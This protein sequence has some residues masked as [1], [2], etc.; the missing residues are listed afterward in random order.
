MF[1]RMKTHLGSMNFHSIDEIMKNQQYLL[2]LLILSFGSLSVSRVHAQEA[3]FSHLTTD[4]G[5]SHN[6]VMAI[7]QDERGLLWFGTRNGVS[8]Y[9]GKEFKIFKQQKDNP[10]SILYNVISDLTGDGNGHVYIM[11]SRGISDYDIHKDTFTPIIQK[12]MRALFFD[13][14][15]YAASS[16]RIFRYENNLFVP[17]YQFPQKEVAI[18]KLYIHNDSVFIGTNQHGL[19]LL[20]PQKEL[21][22]LLPKG[23]IRDILRDSSGNYWITDKQGSGLYQI[24]GSQIT[25]FR[26]V[27]GDPAT[28]SSNIVH[29]CCE[30]KQGNIWVGTFEGLCKYDKKTKQFTRYAKHTTTK[31]L[32]HSSVWSLYC[33]KQ[34]TI[35]AG[36]YFG[37][38]NYINPEKQIYREYQASFQE[39]EGL[40]SPIVGRIIEDNKDNL[41]IC[42]EGG[43]VNKYNRLTR[44]FRWYT[45]SSSP[46]SLSHN[47]IR[48]IYYDSIQSTLWLGTHTG[49]LNKMDLKT[50]RITRYRH[51]EGNKESI[52]SNIIEGIISY[53]GKLLLATHGGI[54]VFNPQTEKCHL[55]LKDAKDLSETKS[56]MGLLFDHKGTLWVTNNNNGASA[57]NFKSKE[58]KTYLHNHAVEHSISSNS[59]NTIYEDSQ[60]RLW[61]CTNEQGLD[62]YRYE[63]DDFENLDVRKNG[64]SSNV[65]YNICELT[66]DRL[67]V[68]TDNGF[69]ILNVSEKRFENYGNLPLSSI[70]E[71]A[72]YK[73]RNGEVFIGGVTGMIAFY[74][75]DIHNTLRSY[76]IFPYR[77]IV[78]GEEITVGDKSGILT[79][80]FTSTP[81]ITLKADQN[82]FSIEYALTDYVPFNKDEIVYRLEGFSD[83]WTNTRGQ[84]TITYTNLSPGQYTLVIKAQSSIERQVPV[85]KLQIEILPP[86]YKTVWAYLIYIISAGAIAYYLVRAYNNH[87]K[88]RESLKFEKKHAED[89]EKLNQAKLRFFTNVSHEFRT[90]LTL[91]IG[92]MEMLLQLRSFTPMVYNKVLG[93]YKISL[94]LKE[95]ITELLDFR[96]QEQGYMSIKVKE[97]NMVDFVYEHYLLFQ[98]YAAQRKITF[99]FQ[100]TN[101]NIPVWYDAKQMQKVMNNLISNAFKHTGEGGE[102]SIS[103]RKRSQEVILEVADNGTGIPLKDIDKIF[104]RFYQIDGPGSLSNTGTGIGLALTKGIIELHHGT[105]EVFSEQGEGATFCVRLKSGNAHFTSEQISEAKEEVSILDTNVAG[106][107]FQ[108]SLLSE[109]QENDT[110]LKARGNKMLIVEDND[111]LRDMLINIFKEFYT[112]ITASNGA[113]GLEKA[114]S[115][116]P[117]IV[118]SDIIMPE[119]SGIELCQSIKKNPDICHIP[120]VLL[121]A[122][123]AIEH[124]IEGL[125]MG[126]DDYITKPFNIRILLSRCNN[127]V[128]NRIML[129]EK[130]SKQPQASANLLATNAMDKAFIDKVVK[131]I[132]THIGNE[133]FNVDMLATE[134]GIARTKLFTKLKAVTGQ[135]PADFIMTYRLKKAAIMLKNNFELNISEIADRLGFSSPAYFSKSFKEKYNVIPQVYR[136]GE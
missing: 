29:K 64:L 104:E 116:Q 86:V 11:T 87:I 117:D 105:I 49:G 22:H 75:K 80:D 108:E 62:L 119:M 55:L 100:K 107:E 31:S 74:E 111:S 13:K 20:T 127:L 136:K 57:Y 113:E 38:V 1:I 35:W 120:V 126:A 91:I 101:N 83:N 78:N 9:N 4:E 125:K 16:S 109:V 128:N 112:V 70:N 94:Q 135:T 99:T 3:S 68:T 42:T 63:T 134:M 45:H 56:T 122:K 24:Q 8:L 133:A 131:V 60:K 12:D 40:S 44:T 81:K 89:I 110:Q 82:V 50:E 14:Q 25:N 27:E 53:Q 61:F 65:V 71:K 96:K 32:S 34:G 76:N 59:I 28:L 121:T 5:L 132:E 37:G 19:Y 124:T 10:N 103:I 58:L 54:G 98:E 23:S 33:D 43:G 39:S 17:F 114:L 7:Y 85:C 77:L 51:Q 66:P 115:E 26:S 67:L 30:D 47:N 52:P 95:L 18:S 72:L 21:V 93:V 129:Q 92:Q 41:W 90:P 130:F 6:S 36:T 15:L 69:S 106:T 118:L 123:T 46:N 88:L 73:A 2:L 48:A 97:H 102:I 84:H 79:Q